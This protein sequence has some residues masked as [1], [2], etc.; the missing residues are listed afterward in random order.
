MLQKTIVYIGGFEM[1]DKNAAAHRVLTNAKILRELGF[2]VV[3]IGVRKGQSEEIAKENCHGFI[4]Y[5]LKYPNSDLEWLKRYF[6]IEPYLAVLRTIPQDQLKAVVFYNEKA[7]L[8]YRVGAWAKA[9]NIKVIGDVTEWYAHSGWGPSSLFKKLDVAIRMHVLNRIADGLITTSSY[10]TNYYADRGIPR[11]KI[12]E[13]PTLFDTQMA[14]L[15]RSRESCS[16]EGASLKLIYCGNPFNVS[17]K[18]GRRYL[19]ERLDQTVDVFLRI[20]ELRPSATL[21][22]F[23]VTVEQ[24]LEY[25]PSFKIK[26]DQCASSLKFHGLVPNHIALDEIAKGDLTIFFRDTN[27]VTLSGFPTKFSES[28]T[29]GTPVI[30][31][32]FPS[33]ER[34]VVPG[35]NCFIV[36]PADTAQ[37]KKLLEPIASLDA[38]QIARIKRACAESKLFDFREYTEAVS[39][40]VGAVGV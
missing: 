30:T 37:L 21:S 1:P 2:R 24:F 39:K 22:V 8:Q 31:N 33:I 18:A 13:L 28:I 26:T 25:Y 14:R 7:F 40:F 9:R 36:D 3:F 29:Y 16:R 38:A 12:I 15:A 6:V 19:K 4:T 32:H 17:P 20:R 10:I 35:N 27:R 23:G 11:Q 5:H 34:Y